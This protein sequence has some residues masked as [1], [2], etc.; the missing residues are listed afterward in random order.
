[1][2]PTSRAT[3]VFPVPGFPTNTR[4]RVMVGAA[5]PALIRRASIRS[6]A[7]WRWISALT[8]VNPVRPSSSASSSSRDLGAGSGG[9]RAADS[10]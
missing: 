5:R 10:A 8:S 1:M 2:P 6:T 4:W 9:S 3:V 7:T